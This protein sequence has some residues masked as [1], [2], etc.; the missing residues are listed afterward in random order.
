MR[1]LGVLMIVFSFVMGVILTL[2]LVDTSHK[3]EVKILEL[4]LQKKQHEL[5][6]KECQALCIQLHNKLKNN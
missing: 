4:Q 5:E 6:L 3:E 2:V 1:E